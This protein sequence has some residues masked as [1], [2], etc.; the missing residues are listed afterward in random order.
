MITD[1]ETNKVYFSSL[2]KTEKYQGF[3]NTLESILVKHK[4]HFDF[5][6]G[7]RDIWCRDYMPIQVN[8]KQFV[9]FKYFPDYC[10]T[11]E[12]IGELTIQ[13]ELEFEY[14]RRTNIKL[15]DLTLDGGNVVKSNNKAILTEK[16]FTENRNRL[17][18]S[19]IKMLRKALGVAELHFIPVQPYDYTG[20][21]DGMV[22]F[23]NENTL[24]V[25]D[26]SSTKESDSWQKKFYK[27]IDK[28]EIDVI[29][30]P[31]AVFEKKS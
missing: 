16:V 5:I 29:P 1:K 24:L 13:R 3:W 20:H 19:V 2:I 17:P 31:Y 12:H 28:I 25:N 11:H 10:L 30:F 8:K 27:A 18:E 6:E 9:Q 7:T 22:R 23:L 21:A 15:V 4:V 26:Y 14:P